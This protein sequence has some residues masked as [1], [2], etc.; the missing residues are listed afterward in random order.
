MVRGLIDSNILVYAANA[1]HDSRHREAKAFM[2]EVM[3]QPDEFVIAQ[4]S[5][6]EF[7]AVAIHRSL[8][9]LPEIE[10]Y[11]TLF[12]DGFGSCFA[13]HPEDI[14]SA[15]HLSK[16]ER[17]HFWDA[18]LASTAQRNGVYLIYTEDAEFER[19]PGI[20]VVNPLQ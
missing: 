17:V 8:L 14:I 13:E 3:R 1:S 2:D 9:P 10:E 11:L 19:I 4:Q 12:K 5:L 16:T 7:A 20:K 15:V 6:R 18:L